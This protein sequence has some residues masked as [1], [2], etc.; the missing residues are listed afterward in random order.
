[1]FPLDRMTEYALEILSELYLDFLDHD[2]L[3]CWSVREL[4]LRRSIPYETSAKVL[5][6]LR[7]AQWVTSLPGRHGGYVLISD[8][9]PQASLRQFL[10]SVD[11]S[12]G[13]LDC[14]ASANVGSKCGRRDCCRVRTPLLELQGWFHESLSKVELVWVL[15]GK[16]IQFASHLETSPVVF[17]ERVV[18]PT[19]EF[20]CP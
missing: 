8:K 15:Q 2:E 5:Q 14:A 6:R 9:I 12:R 19:P 11:P 17:A 4:S 3:R 18:P 16:K 10:E 1:M 7:D 13:A 20:L